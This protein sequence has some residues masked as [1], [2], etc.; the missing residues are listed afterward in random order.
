MTRPEKGDASFPK[1]NRLRQ[2]VVVNRENSVPSKPETRHQVTRLPVKGNRPPLD[3]PDPK[4]KS[5]LFVNDKGKVLAGIINV[6]FAFRKAPELHEAI[7]LDQMSGNIM[8]RKP[9]PTV[10]PPRSSDRALDD[11]DVISLT[12]WLQGKDLPGVQIKTVQ[13]AI[14]LIAREN[15]FHP[16]RDYFDSLTWDGVP[17]VDDWLST[18]LGATNP[19]YGRCVGRLWLIS[20]VARIERPGCQAD[21]MLVLEGPQGARKSTVCKILGGEWFTDHL[22]D[23]LRGK[24]SSIAMKGSWIIEIAEMHSMN[25]G[26]AGALKAFITRTTERYRP[27]YGRFVIEELRQSI[28]IGT[29]NPTSGGYLRDATGAR[30]FWPVKVNN[31]RIDDLRR[32]RDQIWA[33]AVHLYRS[34]NAKWWPDG[35]FEHNYILP[36]Q[37]ERYAFDAWEDKAVGFLDTRSSTTILDFARDVLDMDASKIGRIEQNRIVNILTKYGWVQGSKDPKTRRRL[38]INPNVAKAGEG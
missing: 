2:S 9:L 20:G 13:E 5:R 11:S 38:F 3:G 21:H 16:V 28:M 27:P 4:W 31:I 10:G 18:Y 29:I 23:D 14:T 15:G 17:R 37:S 35:E 36:V 22:P 32:D 34:A 19:E 8:V 6:A 25:K 12:E 7:A 26:E 1:P 30:R 24:D 33:E